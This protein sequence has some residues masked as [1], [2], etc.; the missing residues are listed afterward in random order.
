MNK[1]SEQSS[2]VISNELVYFEIVKESF[3][4]MT[5]L[6]QNGSRPLPTSV[7]GQI[8]SYD[9]EHKSF[10]AAIAT[11]IFSGVYLEALLHRLIVKKD[12]I[13]GYKKCDRN[14][15]EYEKKLRLL[16]CRDE[17]IIEECEHF[18]IVRREL[19]HEKAHLPLH[20]ESIRSAQ[21]EAA[22]VFELLESIHAYFGIDINK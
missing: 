3:L 9:P 17:K 5:S 22:R 8:F 10:K 16:G 2:F 18:R 4:S 20:Q 7:S 6:V 19:V 21:Q 13:E 15:R 1:N 11:I 12:G 14:K